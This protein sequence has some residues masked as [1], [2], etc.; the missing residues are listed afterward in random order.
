MDAE[1]CDRHRSGGA[2]GTPREMRGCSDTCAA[3]IRRIRQA[4][5]AKCLEMGRA[6]GRPNPERDR[7]IIRK[8]ALWGY[9]AT[10]QVVGCSDSCCKDCVKRYAEYAELILAGRPEK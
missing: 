4:G 10:A 2:A 3:R 6:N 8:S 5:L 1:I 7:E 9:K